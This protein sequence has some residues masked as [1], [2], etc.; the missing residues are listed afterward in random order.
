[1]LG[2]V[3][4]VLG[5]HE[6]VRTAGS[7][8]TIVAQRPSPGSMLR[9]GDP[10]EVDFIVAQGATEF[11]PWIIGAA[12]LVLMAA[13]T[14]TVRRLR[15]RKRSSNT[16]QSP[17]VQPRLANSGLDSR[18]GSFTETHPVDLELRITVVRDS[19]RPGEEQ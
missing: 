10:I 6:G 7:P 13:S 5:R 2:A 12:V 9:P 16:A 18:S 17:R 8:G 11:P 14:L 15:K 1:M 19:I 3:G 4:L